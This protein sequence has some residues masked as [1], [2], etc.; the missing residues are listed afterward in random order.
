M[1][2]VEYQCDVERLDRRVGVDTG[3]LAGKL[4]RLATYL[5]ESVD[6]TSE[7]RCPGSALRLIGEHSCALH[8]RHP[9]M[10]GV[11]ANCLEGGGSLHDSKRARPYVRRVWQHHSQAGQ[12]R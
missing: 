2:L 6:L 11:E 4:H 5:L 3:G 9:A 7:Q 10:V 12:L 8:W 1:F